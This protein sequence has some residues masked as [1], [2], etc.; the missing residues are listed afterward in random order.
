MAQ[1]ATRD[2]QHLPSWSSPSRPVRAVRQGV[3][4]EPKILGKAKGSRVG[5]HKYRFGPRV[6]AIRL[7]QVQPGQARARSR[8]PR[9]Q[10]DTYAAPAA[11]PG[12]VAPLPV[13]EHAVV[14][15]R[16]AEPP[17]STRYPPPDIRKTVRRSHCARC[18][19]AARHRLAALC[20]RGARKQRGEREVRPGSGPAGEGFQGRPDR[21]RR[22]GRSSHCVAGL[23]T[24]RV[25][26][27]RVRR[28]RAT[29]LHWRR[30]RPDH[31]GMCDD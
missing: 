31:D 19:A 15:A 2:E 17:R 29:W 25:S 7:E 27:V 30:S 14:L 13:A 3:A 1:A 11:R 6:G 5:A 4:V 9:G 12:G 26:R 10:R 24:L 16:G 18:A 22:H 20:C 23:D 21:D 8:S 28:H